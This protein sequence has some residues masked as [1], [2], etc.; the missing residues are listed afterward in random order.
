MHNAASNCSLFTLN[1]GWREIPIAL[2]M[3]RTVSSRGKPGTLRSVA[4]GF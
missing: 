4:V 1:T 3:R 2:K